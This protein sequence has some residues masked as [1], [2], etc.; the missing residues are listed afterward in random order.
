MTL[1]LLRLLDRLEAL[2]HR[3]HV[4]LPP[5]PCCDHCVLACRGYHHNPCFLC[6][7]ENVA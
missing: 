1:L 4:Y 2:V 6:A 5:R 3:Y 7:K